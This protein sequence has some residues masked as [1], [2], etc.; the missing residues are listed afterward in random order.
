MNRLS[1]APL[2]INDAGPLE[3]IDAAAAGKFD[4]VGLRL[5]PPPDLQLPA[6][7]VGNAPLQ[8]A[9]SRRLADTGI[10]V[11]AATGFFLR[12]DTNG[13]VYAPALDCAARLG[14][15]YFVAVGYLP[16]ED[17]M[18]ES[19]ARLCDQAA[20]FGLK[21]ALE[22]QP[23]G[24]VKT[25]GDAERILRR[26]ARPNG[27]ILVDALHLS[28]SGGAPSDV[29]KLAPDLIGF[30]QLCDAPKLAPPQDGL[31]QESRHG[32][33]LPGEG[34]LPLYELMDALPRD[35]PIDVEVPGPALARLPAA[36]RAIRAA[37]ATRR[38]LDAYRR[39]RVAS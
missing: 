9:I 25:I 37:D 18:A 20:G 3:L 23:Y 31:R 1:L 15:D 12:P 11:F 29:A 35:I 2:T 13:P 16:E 10:S 30:L 32:R 14:A 39:S 28:R 27:A 4:A 33:L 19:F 7:I 21:I 8:R 22:F 26:A 5:L 38:F 36:E 6:E 34:A 24:S 17:R